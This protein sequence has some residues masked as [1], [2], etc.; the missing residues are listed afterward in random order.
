MTSEWL[1]YQVSDLLTSGDILIGDGYR[2]KNE[3]LSPQGIPFA[4]AGNI[5][6]GFNFEGTDCFPEKDLYKL[7]NKI[8][9]PGDVVFTSKGTVGRFAFVTEDTQSFVYSPQL[10]FWRSLNRALIEPRYL[11]YWMMG[12]EFFH[13]Y[14]SVKGQTD[15]ADYVSLSDQRR[16]YIT[17]P[18]IHEQNSIVDIL[19]SLDDKIELNH[20]MNTTLEESARALF[21]SWFVDFDPVRAKMEGRQPEGIDAE[22]AALFPDRLVESTLGMIPEGWGMSS[23]SETIDIIGGGTPKTSNPEFWDGSIPWFSVTDLPSSGDIFVID[24]EKKI[25]QDGLNNSS[26]RMLPYGTTIITARGTVGKVALVGVPMTMN[27]SCYGISGK[28]NYYTFFRLQSATAELKR[29]T[30]GTVFDT[31]TKNTFDQIQ[32]AI[33]SHEIIARFEAQVA[34]NLELMLTNLRLSRTLT[35]TRDSLLPKLLSGEVRVKK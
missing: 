3:E 7:G 24:T 14:N 23:L 12:L 8:S 13:Q 20:R 31:I 10:C 25:T 26:T 22:T 6:G 35:A 32:I 30:H 9:Q 21:K 5:N 1:L 2:A 4:R 27:Q 28:A 34:P 17:L 11:Y 15:M 33:P 19:R 18:S 29:N 16:M